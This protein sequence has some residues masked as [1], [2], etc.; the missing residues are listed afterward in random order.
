MNDTAS[1]GPDPAASQKWPL[2]YD[3]IEYVAVCADVATLVFASAISTLASELHNGRAEGDWASAFGLALGSAIGLVWLL[4][5]HGLY[6]PFELLVLRNQIRGVCIAWTSSLL[7]IWALHGFAVRPGPSQE[8]G[9]LFA[10]F[11]LGLLIAERWGV[12]AL[13]VRCLSGRKFA[14]TNI[15]LITDQP[16]SE[17]AGLSQSLAILGFSVTGRFSLPSTGSGLAWRKRLSARVIEHIRNSNI[18]QVV[19]EANPDRWP[20]LRAFVADL[21]VLPFPIILVPVG[22]ASDLLRHP[23]RRIGGVVCIELQHGPLSAIAN[24]KKRT[25]DLIGAGL[26]LIVLA[27]FIGLLAIAIKL[28]SRGPVLFKQQRCGFN[29]RNF[30]IRKFRTMHVMEDGPIVVQARP[31]D[32]RVTR[33]GKWLRRTS[34]DE[35]PQLLN[36][37][38][39]SMSLVGPRP[40]ALAHD[41]QFNSLLRNYAFRRRVKPGLTGWAQIHGCRGPTP[42]PAAIERRVE[43]D[44]W[45]INNWSLHLDLAILLRTPF[46]VLRGRNAV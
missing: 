5:A 39:G 18:D 26:A 12:R 23:T 29:G 16:L 36:V 4:K 15:V 38:D 2:R 20:D 7:L 10:V 46:E 41:G 27:P 43:Y 31:A 3:S 11:G 13:L 35:L 44:L 21:G 28:D 30:T 32:H 1:V 19:V 14:G 22:A 25:I 8:V 37:L 33:V 17:Y 45:Y 42:D 6:Q 40:H 24:A 34:L 9:L